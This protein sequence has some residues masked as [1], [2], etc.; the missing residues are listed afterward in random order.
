MTFFILIKSSFFF[1]FD[2]ISLSPLPI[3]HS[4]TFKPLF[5]TNLTHVA[6]SQCLSVWK[7]QIFQERISR[8]KKKASDASGAK[9]IDSQVTETSLF[10]YYSLVTHPVT[11]L[12]QRLL[13]FAQV[14]SFITD[15]LSSCTLM[16]PISCKY[17][18]YLFIFHFGSF[19]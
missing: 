1:Q 9:T 7:I 13:F 5:F 2:E 3:T 4:V 10:D 18:N 19:N 6:S 17:L 8:Q 15:F 14:R 16:M 12:K 11:L